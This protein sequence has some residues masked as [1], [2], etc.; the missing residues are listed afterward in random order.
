MNSTF[1]PQKYYSAIQLLTHLDK[2]A[3][4]NE[5][6]LWQEWLGIG[7][8][9]TRIKTSMLN[10]HGKAQISIRNMAQTHGQLHLNWSQCLET[11]PPLLWP[12]HLNFSIFTPPEILRLCLKHLSS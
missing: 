1:H 10:L 8:L 7:I 9:T 12:L 2:P 11:R 6:A 5:T 4:L 3:V